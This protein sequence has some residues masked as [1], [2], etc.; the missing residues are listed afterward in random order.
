MITADYEE[1]YDNELEKYATYEDYLDH[2]IEDQDKE[3]LANIELARQLIELGIHSKQPILKK[4]QFEAKQRALAEAKKNQNNDKVK[5]LSHKLVP[6][7]MWKDDKFLVEIA[8]REEDVVYGQ[9]GHQRK[10]DGDH[11][12]QSSETKAEEQQR[13]SS[14][15]S[16]GEQI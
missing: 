2:F 7:E 9:P 5:E 11:I 1:Y 4:E 8:K 14:R 16:K 3:Y 6:E 12:H 13:P 10:A 15:Q